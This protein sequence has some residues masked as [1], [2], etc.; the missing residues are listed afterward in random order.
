MGSS[1]LIGTSGSV[2]QDFGLGDSVISRAAKLRLKS[3]FRN[4]TFNDH[5]YLSD[6]QTPRQSRLSRA[7]AICPGFIPS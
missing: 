4:E 2:F 1:P 3:E 5:T 6:W 7:A